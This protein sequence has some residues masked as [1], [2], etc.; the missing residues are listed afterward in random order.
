MVPLAVHLIPSQNVHLS[1]VP[2]PGS[3]CTQEVEVEWFLLL[4]EWPSAL[5][6]QN[7]GGPP[8]SGLLWQELHQASG[9]YA[10][11]FFSSK[12]HFQMYLHPQDADIV[13]KQWWIRE[14]LVPC[15]TISS[16]G[17]WDTGCVLNTS[18][19]QRRRHE[20]VTVLH[21]LCWAADLF[22]MLLVC[23]YDRTAQTR[24]SPGKKLQEWT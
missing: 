7:P 17:L 10:L 15:P 24:G 6:W 2:F 1:S 12:S 4:L 16:C 21:Q 5:P 9:S 18:V 22:N 11:D 13:K 14:S 20:D 3:S 8:D 19:V 23:V